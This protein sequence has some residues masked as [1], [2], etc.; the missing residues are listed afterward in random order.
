MY[1]VNVSSVSKILFSISWYRIDCF[2]FILNSNT[3]F[4]AFLH[5]FYLK[6][7]HSASGAGAEG[8]EELKEGCASQ[9]ETGNVPKAKVFAHPLPFN[10]IPHIDKFQGNDY[11]KEVS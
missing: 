9:L 2:L 10:V 8:M 4:F 6:R 5:I 1:C 7:K 11:T 3:T